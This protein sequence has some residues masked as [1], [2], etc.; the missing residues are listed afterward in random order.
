MIAI[1]HYS[2]SLKRTHNLIQKFQFL[3]LFG[4]QFIAS[5]S[6]GIYLHFGQNR[7]QFREFKWYAAG[8]KV[9]DL[10]YYNSPNGNNK[11]LA[12]EALT[13]A[14]EELPKL[15]SYL[16]YKMGNRVQLMLFESLNDYRQSSSGFQNPE[17]ITGGINTVPND[18]VNIYFN[19][20]RDYLRFQIRQGICDAIIREMIY[21]GSLQERFD[22]IKAPALPFWF[23]AGLSR[24]LAE[25][26][27]VNAENSL[28]EGFLNRKMLN[29][30]SMSDENLRIA[31]QSIWRYLVDYYGPEALSAVIF[32]AR[33]SNSAEIAMQFKTGKPMRIFLSEWRKHYDSIFQAEE[34]QATLPKGKANIPGR[35]AVLNHTGFAF[36][37]AGDKVALVTNKL[38][39]FDVWIY[40]LNSGSTK[41]IYRGG[42]RIL[43]Q[44]PDY[45]FPKLQWKSKNITLLTYENGKYKLLSLNE[46]GNSDLLMEFSGFQ[47]VNEFDISITGDS[48]LF[49][50]VRKNHCDIYLAIISSKK[51]I[52][53]SFNRHFEH[54]P[55]F[56]AD[57]TMAFI[58][59]SAVSDLWLYTKGKLQNVTLNK[60]KMSLSDPILYNDSIAGVLSD[61]TGIRN[62]WLINT[63]RPGLMWGQT[64]YRRSVIAQQH[65][66]NKTTLGELLLYKGKHTLFTGDMAQNP[67]NDTISVK[68]ISWINRWRNPDSVLRVSEKQYSQLFRIGTDTSGHEISV[69]SS[70]NYT[71]QTG[72]PRIDFKSEVAD[73]ELLQPVYQKRTGVNPWMPD[74]II[75]LSDN[76]TLGS[77]LFNMNLP[78]DM[79]RNP[80]VMPLIGLSLS[81]LYKTSRIEAGARSNFGLRSTDFY[82]QS[83]LRRGAFEHEFFVFRRSRKFDD[84]FNF[85]KQNL[86]GMAEYRLWKPHNES[87]KTGITLGYRRESIITKASEAQ[88]L[89]LPDINDHYAL[90]RTE[91]IYD[92]TIGTAFNVSEG[93]R[94]RFGV[95]TFVNLVSSNRLAELNMDVRKYVNLN[96]G[97]TFA[98]RIAAAYNLSKSKI[99]YSLG[100]VENWLSS[101]QYPAGTYEP[102][103]N[104]YFFKSWVCNL[105]GFYRGA[106]VGSNFAVVNAELRFA[107]FKSIV[108]KPLSN[109]FLKNFTITAFADAG[110]AFTGNTPKD[111]SNPFNTIYLNY[112]NYSISVT[113]GR[114]PWL[115]GSG[116][117][118][119]SRILGYFIKYDYAWGYREGRWQRAV[120]YLSLGLDF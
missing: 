103:G 2:L 40:N 108:K 11:L 96:K 57:G 9:A 27:S 29:F 13:I 35:I 76:K 84:Q 50:A 64:N 30:N 94:G 110:T 6:Q 86:T 46:T 33:Y 93:L 69:G 1:G 101:A 56:G 4:L 7:V 18:V 10:Y 116:L 109:E 97:L 87:L 88:A 77:Y 90:V 85:F 54:S 45:G 3:L 5:S 79:M 15:E 73:S 70:T 48:V 78:S 17:W 105:R 75:T 65:N 51:N 32:M 66:L 59:D 80:V 82:L 115:L 89:L 42:H 31:G 43:N 99:A 26:W 23:T 14:G 102:S 21:G 107:V 38:G 60:I 92:N 74:Y 12:E 83:A 61:I 41:H 44:T 34:K 36:N 113:S 67:W 47:S 111:P 98:G 8:S 118:I 106:R 95:Q 68:K 120:G 24:F 62:A 63:N 37:P 104:Q 55:M 72:F 20:D 25:G 117:G 119:R 52:Q 22:R 81:D 100:G 19:G 114:S 71:F 39:R 112:P 16:A 91:I 53:I 28:R 49:T 58:S